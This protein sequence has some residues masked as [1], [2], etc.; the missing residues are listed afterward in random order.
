VTAPDP[1]SPDSS[2][3]EPSDPPNRQTRRNLWISVVVGV[4]IVVAV[5][6]GVAIGHAGGGS[7]NPT[8]TSTTTVTGAA[9]TG[10][11]PAG[12]ATSGTTGAAPA[13]TAAAGCAPSGKGVP[14]G[15]GT[16]R[17]IDVDGDGRPDTGWIT[18]GADRR[19]GI[20]TA[21]GATF[22]IKITSASPEPASAIVQR[23]DPGIPIALVDTGREV[24]LYSAAHCHLAA[25]QNAT[26]SSYTFDKGFTGYGTGVGCTASGERLELAGLL[27][28]KDDG[29]STYTV[30]RTFVD[31][32]ADGGHATNGTPQVVAKD[33][34]ASDAVVKTAQE[35]TC[36]DL[37]AGKDGPVEP[38][39]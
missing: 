38:Q 24:L 9:A 3:A 25:T 11:P 19:F 2:S 7:S 28:K 6:V 23:V 29:T 39:D 1:S 36:G 17:I 16:H 30:T 18:A 32:D 22:S 31:L 33:A 35:T 15:A 12:T 21:S 5:F 26:G 27:A 14:K 13:T 8:V 4:V 10:A 37:R 34:K 20:T